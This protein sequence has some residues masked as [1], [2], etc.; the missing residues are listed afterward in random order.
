MV[1]AGGVND[2][3]LGAGVNLVHRRRM[4]VD[5]VEVWIVEH[6]AVV[7]ESLYLSLLT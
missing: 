4:L 1:S 6:V 2:G 3:V 5:G 7:V